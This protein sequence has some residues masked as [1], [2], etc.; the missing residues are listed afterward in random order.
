MMAWLTGG[1]L[2]KGFFTDRLVETAAPVPVY[3]SGLSDYCKNRIKSNSN[4]NW[5]V[6]TVWTG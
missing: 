4:S 2:A 5:T 6:Q 3:R 1:V